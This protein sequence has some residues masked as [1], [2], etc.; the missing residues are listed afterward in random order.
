MHTVGQKVRF[1]ESS[2]EW[3]VVEVIDACAIYQSTYSDGE[4][5][6]YQV[7]RADNKLLKGGVG[8]V[9]GCYIQ[10]MRDVARNG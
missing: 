4:K 3:E 9:H 5:G 7:R 6:G 8:A 10:S 2:L 1:E